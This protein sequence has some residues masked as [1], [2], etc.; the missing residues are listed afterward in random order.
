MLGR[1]PQTPPRSFGSEFLLA[2]LRLRGSVMMPGM[3]NQILAA[4]LLAAATYGVL[5][6]IA[7]AKVEATVGGG[8]FPL[9]DKR[10]AELAAFQRLRASLAEIGE[11]GLADRLERLRQEEAIWVAPSLGPD[12]W[13]VFA[14]SLRLVRRIYI[15]RQ[16]LLDP[17]AHLYPVALADIPDANQRA[18]AWISLA[19][20]L[21]HELAHYAGMTD[22]ADA[23]AAEIAWYEGLRASPWFA[24][25]KGTARGIFDWALESAVL[26][27][28]KASEKPARA[29]RG[30]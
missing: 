18:F 15:R 20:A 14:E 12:R 23:Y 1:T 29:P 22:E 7:E 21:R 28:R 16:A 2:R 19:G 11:H 30:H 25:L 3:R 17:R 9:D 4:V 8:A 27:A 13:A 24:S 5:L 26:T 6:R 10:P